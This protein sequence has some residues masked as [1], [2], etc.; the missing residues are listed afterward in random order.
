MHPLV[1][2]HCA[3]EAGA[4]QNRGL[5]FRTT[6]TYNLGAGGA[7]CWDPLTGDAREGGE[8]RRTMVGRRTRHASE[9]TL[10]RGLPIE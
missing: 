9:A 10:S 1:A 5:G 7:F 3:S 2:E 8:G 4:S 6:K